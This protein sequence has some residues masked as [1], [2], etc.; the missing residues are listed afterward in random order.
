MLFFHYSSD[1]TSS[2][3]E[4]AT[5]NRGVSRSHR[6]RLIR[7][8]KVGKERD[9]NGEA[10]EEDRRQARG[11]PLRRDEEQRVGHF[12]PLSINLLYLLF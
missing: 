8:Q 3:Y 9:P 10:R 1:G 12:R 4:V 11:N 2:N 7:Q 5:G 6:Q